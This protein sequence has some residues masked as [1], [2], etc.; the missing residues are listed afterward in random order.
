MPNSQTHLASVDEMLKDPRIRAAAPWLDEPEPRAA[1]YLGAISPDARIISRQSREETHFYNI[2]PEPAAPPAHALMLVRW[3]EL[4]A[5]EHRAVAHRAFV[6][7][8]ITHLVMDQTWLADIVMPS[9]YMND[10]AWNTQ[11]PRWR[12]YC[13]LMSYLEYRAEAQIHGSHIA[14]L[15]LA[16]PQHWLPFLGDMFLS[17]WRD[18]VTRHIEKGGARQ[19]SAM[20]ARSTG[21]TAD[22]LEAIVRSEERMREEA[23]EVVPHETLLDFEADA[24]RRS[25]EAV[26]AYLQPQS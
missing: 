8:Y 24:T 26:L 4:A 7:G 5:I 19:V 20:F 9:L 11:H 18:P 2:P 1:F 21:M 14:S 22:E 6:A 10:V 25:S 3:P 16:R 12:L 23:Y 15:R 17:V 13:L